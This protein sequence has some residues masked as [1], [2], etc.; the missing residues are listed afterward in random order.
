MSAKKATA[1]QTPLR[2]PEMEEGVAHVSMMRKNVVFH[3]VRRGHEVYATELDTGETLWA[4][5]QNSGWWSKP[6]F[7]PVP[8]GDVA[9]D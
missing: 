6:L 7:I 9:K 2:A 3:Y 4:G 1:K 8:E 5:N